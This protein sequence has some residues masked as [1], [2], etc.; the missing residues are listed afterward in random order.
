VIVFIYDD[1]FK[2]NENAKNKKKPRDEVVGFLMVFG[3]NIAVERRSIVK[4]ERLR[5]LAKACRRLFN[6]R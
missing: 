1:I 4:V 5:R 2:E 6:I 3:E